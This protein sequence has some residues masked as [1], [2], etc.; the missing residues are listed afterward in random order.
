MKY[1]D[2]K[3]SDIELRKQ[4]TLVRARSKKPCSI[5]HQ[6]TEF[7]EFCSES[8]ICSEECMEKLNSWLNENCRG[9]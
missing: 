1:E 8:Y 4:H 7:I 6:Q 2:L 3:L 5:C 9:D